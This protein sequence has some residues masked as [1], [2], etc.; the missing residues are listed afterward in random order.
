LTISV[1]NKITLKNRLLAQW[2]TIAIVLILIGI[3]CAFLYGW[4]TNVWDEYRLMHGGQIV[5]GFITETWEDVEDAESGG[6]IWYYG[7]ICTYQL[8]D[9]R[10][11]EGKLNGEGKLKS[12][13]N[14]VPYPIEVTYLVGNPTVSRIT[15]DLSDSTLGLLRDQ[16]FPLLPCYL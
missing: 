4:I 6:N 2:K 15:E 5:Q 8:P 11:L 9:G 1:G 14:N 7:V 16:I 13:F 3:R 12:E 10:E